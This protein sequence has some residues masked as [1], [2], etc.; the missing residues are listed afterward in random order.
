MIT[1][2]FFWGKSQVQG[3]N[4]RQVKVLIESFNPRMS[5]W[6]CASVKA[7]I[8]G[9]TLQVMVVKMN[10]GVFFLSLSRK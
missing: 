2:T 7:H 1:A 6:L 10:L 3:R 4:W 5:A 8:G 9:L